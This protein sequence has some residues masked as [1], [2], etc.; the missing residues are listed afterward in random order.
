MRFQVLDEDEE[1]EDG[2]E[3]TS[4][5]GRGQLGLRSKCELE[6]GQEKLGTPWSW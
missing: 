5:A 1:D 4:R 3:T 6:G 2:E